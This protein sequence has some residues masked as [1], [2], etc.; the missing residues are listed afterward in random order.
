VKFPLSQGKKFLRLAKSRITQ[1]PVNN[2]LATSGHKL[3]GMTKQNLIVSQLN[4]ST[5]NWVY[6]VLSRVT[7][8]NGLFLLQP[9]K[10]NFNPQPSKV[11][12]NEWKR[13]RDQELELLLFLRQLWNFPEDVNVN[14]LAL[15]ID[16][17]RDNSLQTQTTITLLKKPKKKKAVSSI[18][19]KIQRNSTYYKKYVL[20]F[21]ENRLKIVPHLSNKSGNCLFESVASFLEVWKGKPVELRYKSLLWAKTQVSQGTQ[22]GMMMWRNFE[23]TKAN[24]DCYNKNSYM[25]YLKFMKDPKVFGTEYDIIMLYEFLKVSIKV[26]SPSLF[27]KRTDLSSVKNL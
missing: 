18:S 7:S 2:D 3:Q 21:T 15:K 4:Y 27:L 9:I 5:P 26:F 6:V 22:W 23:V 11:L 8:L 10:E 12:Q 17:M 20:W 14:D 24:R 19:T 1:F 25:E 13:Q 16:I